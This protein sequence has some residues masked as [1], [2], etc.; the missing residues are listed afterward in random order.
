M[1]ITRTM[2]EPQ[3]QKDVAMDSMAFK[4]FYTLNLSLGKAAL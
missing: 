3:L 4:S 1:R 2:V